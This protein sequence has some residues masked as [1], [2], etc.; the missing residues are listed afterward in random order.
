ML[1]EWNQSNE[2]SQSI[3]FLNISFMKKKYTIILSA[4]VVVMGL[5]GYC[6]L[7]HKEKI[8]LI[9]APADYT[10]T[11]EQIIHDFESNTKW[12]NNRY[13]KKA[14]VIQGTVSEMHGEE[15]ILNDKIVC[16]LTEYDP[17]IKAGQPIAIKGRI[18][19]FD[20]FMDEVKLENCYSV[21]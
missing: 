16:A 14:V 21:K 3:R 6:Y 15:V 12:A 19:A 18:I 10:I 11:S 2:L 7:M 5:G 8:D 13:L 1:L 4:A 20:D 17:K 9:H